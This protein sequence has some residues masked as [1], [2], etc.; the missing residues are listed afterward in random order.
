MLCSPAAARRSEWRSISGPMAHPPPRE[1]W[2]IQQESTIPKRNPFTL[3]RYQS[4][5]TPQPIPESAGN[6]SISGNIEGSATNIGP[7]SVEDSR[8]D[9]SVLKLRVETAGVPRAAHRGLSLPGDECNRRLS[10]RAELEP[11]GGSRDSRSPHIDPR[12][13]SRQ[14][15]C[16]VRHLAA[17]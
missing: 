12:L 14:T 6:G 15:L 11:R 3:A 4:A 9:P 17:E 8:L 7:L 16:R 1:R 10:H 2:I 13:V 5:S